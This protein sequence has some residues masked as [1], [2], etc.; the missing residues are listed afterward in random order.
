MSRDFDVFQPVIGIRAFVSGVAIDDHHLG[1][2][3]IAGIQLPQHGCGFDFVGHRHGLHVALNQVA[4]DERG[5]VL[6][7]DGDDASSKGIAP[8]R[9][10]LG[11]MARTEEKRAKQNCAKNWG[12]SEIHMIQ[13]N[14]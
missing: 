9:L 4:V 3:G 1:G 8:G 5:L 10:R 2:N 12:D 14:A 6:G 13:C 7:V 11:A